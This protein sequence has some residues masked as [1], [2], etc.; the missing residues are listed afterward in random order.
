MRR[1][2]AEDNLLVNDQVSSFGTLI[3][4]LAFQ[5]EQVQ[6]IRLYANIVRTDN[7]SPGKPLS[8]LRKKLRL[9]LLAV[10]TA[11]LEKEIDLHR[12]RAA[13][14]PAKNQGRQHS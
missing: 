13:R 12:F 11:G 14:E 4:Q 9:Y 5:L 3:A 10:V 7:A 2:R 6:E 1:R 8:N